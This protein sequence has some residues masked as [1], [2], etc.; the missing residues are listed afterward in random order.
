[1]F[2][3]SSLANWAVGAAIFTALATAGAGCT[4]CD[5]GSVSCDANGDCVIC[6]AYGCRSANPETGAT[7]G[8]ATTTGAGGAGGLGSASGGQPGDGGSGGSG[9]APCDGT[10]TTCPCEAADDCGDDKQCI[11]GL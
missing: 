5:K 6:D 3:R 1:M 2:L 7:V 9:G 8:A 11:D 4:G 10:V